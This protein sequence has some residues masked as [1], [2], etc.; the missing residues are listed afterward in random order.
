MGLYC[1]FARDWFGTLFVIFFL[2]YKKR[3]GL[4]EGERHTRGTDCPWRRRQAGHTAETRRTGRRRDYT[5][6]GSHPR[7][8]WILAG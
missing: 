1:V 2:D 6:R 7:A 8:A 5:R 3:A 4:L